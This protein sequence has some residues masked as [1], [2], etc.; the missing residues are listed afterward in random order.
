MVIQGANGCICGNFDFSFN[1]NKVS[2]N[3]VF[4]NFQRFLKAMYIMYIYL[5]NIFIGVAWRGVA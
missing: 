5:Y 1:V 4:A 3:P 2:L